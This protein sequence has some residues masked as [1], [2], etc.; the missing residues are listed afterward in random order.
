MHITDI[1]TKTVHNDTEFSKEVK[2]IIIVDKWLQHSLKRSHNLKIISFCLL[3]LDLNKIPKCKTAS[4]INDFKHIPCTLCILHMR[5]KHCSSNRFY[6]KHFWFVLSGWDLT[7]LVVSFWNRSYKNF[8][9]ELAIESVILL[10]LLWIEQ[11]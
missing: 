5:G 8:M 10:I 9:Q 6:S 11:Y 2:I 4:M 3:F 1:L 7:Q